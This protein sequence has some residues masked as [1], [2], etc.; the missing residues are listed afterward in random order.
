MTRYEQGFL[1]KCAEF[2]VDARSV[3][4]YAMEKSALPYNPAAVRSGAGFKIGDL[5]IG[6]GVLPGGTVGAGIVSP[7]GGAGVGFRSN[8][9]GN[10]VLGA[11]AGAL[12]GLGLESLRGDDRKQYLKRALRMA[13]Y[14]ALA[15]GVATMATSAPDYLSRIASHFRRARS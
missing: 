4:R 7:S 1:N 8:V 3:A 12:A 15:G 5:A 14:G 10:S 9:I 2:G 6:G 11:G 13:L